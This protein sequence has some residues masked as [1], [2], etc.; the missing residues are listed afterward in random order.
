[1]A[2]NKK[3]FQFYPGKKYYIEQDQKNH[4]R[5]EYEKHNLGRIL[6]YGIFDYMINYK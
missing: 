3:F 5:N 2:E 1:L 6:V 4:N